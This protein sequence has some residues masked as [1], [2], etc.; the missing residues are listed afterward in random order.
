[1]SESQINRFSRRSLLRYSAAGAAAVGGGALISACGGGSSGGSGSGGGQA[2]GLS[3]RVAAGK[4][5]RLGIANEPP[6]TVLKPNGTLTGAAPDVAKAVLERMGIGADQVKP[7]QTDYAGMIPGLKAH[8]WDMVTAGMFMNKERCAEVLYSDP[9]IV[10]TESFALTPENSSGVT[11]IKE[12]KAHSDFKIAVLQGS[13][14]LEIAKSLGVPTS[15]LSTYPRAPKALSALE[16]GRVDA[17]LLPTA[18][19]KNSKKNTG[20]KFTITPPLEAFPV[21]GSGAAFRPSDKD[22]HA[23]YNKELKNLKE[24]GTFEKI[25]DKWGFSAEAARNATTEQLCKNG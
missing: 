10:S 16:A 4:P 24:S 19:L 18:T 13:F 12:A 25:L 7:Q 3:A 21:T 8:R 2:Q 5:V 14:E 17:V 15:Q 11:T 6:Y 20:G 23:K 22:F 1:M 9:V